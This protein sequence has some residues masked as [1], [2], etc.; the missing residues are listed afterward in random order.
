MLRGKQHNNMHVSFN[1]T[2]PLIEH[3]I[4]DEEFKNGLVRKDLSLTQNSIVDNGKSPEG[5]TSPGSK[6]GRWAGSK[7]IRGKHC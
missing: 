4:Q 7:P 5:E 2:N 1:E 6:Y 3:D